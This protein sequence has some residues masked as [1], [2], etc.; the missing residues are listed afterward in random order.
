MMSTAAVMPIPIP[1]T[2]RPS[3]IGSISNLIPRAD[4]VDSR[5]CLLVVVDGHSVMYR[6]TVNSGV[7]FDQGR[8]FDAVVKRGVDNAVNFD[9]VLSV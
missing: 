4:L 7:H 9:L 5:Y 8:L 2:C 3:T 1:L 6:L